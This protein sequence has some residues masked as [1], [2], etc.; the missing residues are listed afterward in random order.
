MSHLCGLPVPH[1][2]SRGETDT[3]RLRGRLFTLDA[4][5]PR[6][7]AIPHGTNSR[8]MKLQRALEIIGQLAAR[9]VVAQGVLNEGRIFALGLFENDEQLHGRI[10]DVVQGL[11][12]HVGQ[13]FERHPWAFVFDMSTVKQTGHTSPMSMLGVVWPQAD[14]SVVVQEYFLTGRGARR[15]KT[16][17][18]EHTPEGTNLSLLGTSG[19]S[20][21]QTEDALSGTI[22]PLAIAILNTRGCSIDH[23]QAP[24]LENH[25]RTRM[26]QQPL[27]AHYRV[28]ATEYITALGGT[29]PARNAGGTHASPIPHLRRAHERVLADGRRIWIPSALV[30]VRSEGDIAFVERRKGYRSKD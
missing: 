1:S 5:V 19:L 13:P 10:T 15:M 6:F 9:Q 28:D 22:Y 20:R 3:R 25:R 2:S 30:N 8:T 17:R 14:G 12:E 16:V 4:A 7:P 18:Y 11:R 26:G 29:S 21:E 24:K 27:P 23:K